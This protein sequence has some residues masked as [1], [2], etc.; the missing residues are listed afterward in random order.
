M[1][2]L[3]AI[4]LAIAPWQG[5]D[6]PTATAAAAKYKLTVS[7]TPGT[8]THLRTSNVAAGWIAAF[9]NDRVCS[10]NRVDQTI[11]ESGTVMLQ[12]E[13]IREEGTAPHA[14]GA[15]I[16]S[17]DGAKITVVPVSR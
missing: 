11:P 8:I 6:L 10:P 12:F 14:S 4:V 9:C 15:T 17:D 7:G 16:S 13:L 3:L 5:K 2:A 1:G